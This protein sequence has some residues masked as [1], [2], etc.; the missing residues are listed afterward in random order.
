MT[1]RFLLNPG[2]TRGHR[3]RLQK[4]HALTG[5]VLSN[6]KFRIAGSEMQ[7]SSDFKIPPSSFAPQDPDET[8]VR[9]PTAAIRR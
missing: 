9:L 8:T 3:P 5:L 4:T 7:D 6:L 2:N 1:A